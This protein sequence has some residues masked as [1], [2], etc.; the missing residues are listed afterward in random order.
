MEAAYHKPFAGILCIFKKLFACMY[1]AS[2]N[3]Q[4]ELNM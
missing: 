3:K 2:I 4:T 1:V